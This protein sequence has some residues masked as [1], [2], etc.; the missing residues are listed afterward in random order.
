MIALAVVGF[1]G[2]A[3]AMLLPRR[4]R[5]GANGL[6]RPRSCGD[7]NAGTTKCIGSE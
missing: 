3:A 2:L 7:L 4:I 6:T 1:V 5:H